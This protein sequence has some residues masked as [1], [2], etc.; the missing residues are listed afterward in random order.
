MSNPSDTD[1]GP[2]EWAWKRSIKLVPVGCGDSLEK[3]RKRVATALDAAVEYGRRLGRTESLETYTK[4]LDESYK[5]DVVDADQAGYERGIREG[6][7]QCAIAVSR[8][9]VRAGAIENYRSPVWRYRERALAVIVN[10][11]P[12]STRRENCEY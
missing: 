11:P 6:R 8:I 3:I 1:K 2:S 4:P 12:T 5:K 10:P 9:P 7:E